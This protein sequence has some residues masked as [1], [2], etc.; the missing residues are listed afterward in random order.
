[1]L[2]L[3]VYVLLLHIVFVAILLFVFVIILLFVFH[4]DEGDDVDDDKDYE[5]QRIISVPPVR[6][7]HRELSL[8]RMMA[9]MMMMM[10]MVMIV[11]MMMMKRHRPVSVCAQHR[12]PRAIF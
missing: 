1:M 2:L 12:E 11:M 4:N 7:Q 6:A 9:M 10:M 8:M 3:F 5:T